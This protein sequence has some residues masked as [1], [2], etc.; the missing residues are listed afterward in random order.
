MPATIE[1]GQFLAFNVVIEIGFA[2][3]QGGSIA[4]LTDLRRSGRPGRRKNSNVAY[5]AGDF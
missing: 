5:R 1:F 2:K 3:V 4:A